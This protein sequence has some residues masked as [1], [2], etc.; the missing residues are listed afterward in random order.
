LGVSR[1][2]FPLMVEE[3]L[4]ARETVHRWADWVSASR[5][6]EVGEQGAGRFGGRGGGVQFGVEKWSAARQPDIWPGPIR[7]A[8]STDA[9]VWLVTGLKPNRGRSDDLT[10]GGS[11]VCSA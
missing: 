5:V 8:E 11:S 7:H 4:F 9:E 6:G 3:D 10:R 2:D 1:V